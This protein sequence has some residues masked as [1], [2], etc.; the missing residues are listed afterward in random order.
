MVASWALSE[1]P[2]SSSGSTIPYS[3]LLTI[4][5]IMLALLLRVKVPSLSPGECLLSVASVSVACGCCVGSSCYW[6][7]G[8]SGVMWYSN[9]SEYIAFIAA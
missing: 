4:E 7:S 3:L 9:L 5:D 6:A 2:S 1:Q 8:V